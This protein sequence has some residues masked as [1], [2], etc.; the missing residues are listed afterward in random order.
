M[1]YSAECSPNRL[2]NVPTKDLV[3]NE[4]FRS[5]AYASTVGPPEWR[6]DRFPTS[7]MGKDQEPD[8]SRREA[9]GFR[10]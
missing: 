1:L 3:V 7:G 2:V 10:R 9:L 4:M 8:Y 5:T 6:G